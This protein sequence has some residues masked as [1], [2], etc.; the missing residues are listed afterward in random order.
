VKTLAS[1]L[2]LEPEADQPIPPTVYNPAICTDADL[3]TCLTGIAQIT[4]GLGFTDH[5]QTSYREDGRSASYH[6]AFCDVERAL[7][8]DC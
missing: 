6:A 3:V 1:S 8:G 5:P 7:F 2:I 4:R